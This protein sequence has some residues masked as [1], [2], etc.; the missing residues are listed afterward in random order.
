[1]SSYFYSFFKPTYFIKIQ[2]IVCEFK[3]CH[4][5]FFSASGSIHD[6]ILINHKKYAIIDFLKF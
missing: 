5:L 6:F 1:M 4:T 3:I 2:D